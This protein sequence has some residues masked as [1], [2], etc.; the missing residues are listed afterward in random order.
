MKEYNIYISACVAK[1]WELTVE[2]QELIKEAV[3]AAQTSYSPYS[4]FAVGA[5][6]K[7]DTGEII[8][9]SNQENASY[10]VGC[11]A[12][13]TAL[14]WTGANR[15][16]ATICEMAI[17]SINGGQ[18]TKDITAPCG[19]CR[20]ALLE[21]E[22]R[23]NSPIRVLLCGKEDVYI[24]NQAADLLPLGFNAETLNV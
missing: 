21:V 10:P 4:H 15:K 7:I 23:Q 19:M 22:H 1:Q 6:L 18:V 5:A 12:E 2:E 17:V 8:K 13:R 16:G 3:N 14:F 11:C 20:Q 9:G 24:F